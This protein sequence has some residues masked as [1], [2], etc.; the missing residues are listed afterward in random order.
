MRSTRRALLGVFLL[1][2][3]AVLSDGTSSYAK[4]D[5]PKE[6]EPTVD[7]KDEVLAWKTKDGLEYHYRLPREGRDQ[8]PWTMTVILH[9]SN[10][11]KRWGFA[12]HSWK[13]FRPYDLVVSPDGTTPNGNGGFNSLGEAKDVKRVEALIEEIKKALPVERVLLYGH[14][15]GS[16]FALHYAGAKPDDVQGVVA[17]ASG[18]WTWTQGGPKSHHQAIC[19]MHGTRDPVVP[20][21]QSLGGYDALKKA[22]YPILRMRSLEGW[23]HWPAEHNGPVPHTSQQ[24]AWCDAMTGTDPARLE[25]SLDVLADVKDPGQHDFA[26]L[27]SAASRVAELEDAPEDLRK[28]A[29]DLKAKVEALAAKHVEALGAIPDDLA[30]DGKPWMGHLGL[31]LRHFDDVPACAELR[32]RFAKVL[33]ARDK[34]LSKAWGQWWKA[35]K[36]N[37]NADAF[38]AGLVILGEGFLTVAGTDPDITKAMDE[39]ASDAKGNK[40]SRKATKAWKDVA[41]ALEKGLKDAWKDFEKVN[42][43]FGD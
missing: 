8:K 29:A 37:D 40:L 3:V 26:G 13:E 27:W 28:K 16:F 30:P 20:Y 17:H 1:G 11:D 12:N 18:I 5:G 9:G 21:G 2:L 32:E 19:F 38:D 10:L 4:D 14:S 31:F 22:R 23:N 35:R 25:R 33:E 43:R 39:W 42:R 24:L 6:A 36:G 7:G 15:Q 34:K 41:K